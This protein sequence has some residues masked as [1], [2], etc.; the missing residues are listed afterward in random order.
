MPRRIF[1]TGLGI[2]TG[3]G[4]NLAETKDSLFHLRTG[5]GRIRYLNAGLNSDIPVSEVKCSFEE[6]FQLAG[7]P[8][9]E[10]Y[11]RNALLGMIAAKEAYLDARIADLPGLR[12]GL[13]SATTVGGMDRCELYFD[14]FL[15]N[16]SKNIYIDTYD[17]ADSTEKIADMLGIR[18]YLTT[19]STACSSSANAIQ[20]GARMILNG[21]L[22]RV[23][24][25]G[26]E[27]LTKF[28]LF[29]FD[30]LKILDKEISKPFDE[31]RN[32]I[33]LGEGAAYLVLESEESVKKSGKRILCELTG[34]GNACEAFHQ[35]ASSPDGIGAYL[36]MKKA[37]DLSGLDVADIDYINAHGTGTDNNDISEGRAIQ[38][39][40]GTA[41]PPVSSTKPYTGHTT[42]AAGATEAI[43]SIL[44][45]LEQVIWPNLNFS[46]PMKDLDFLPVKE[47]IR[48]KKINHVMSNSFGF[49]GNDTSL[50]FSRVEP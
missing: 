2:I 27:T 7:I 5:I 35:T 22:D 9:S 38:K 19:I 11:S 4:N 42:S 45:L 15:N 30:A 31:N 37:V 20:L 39:L 16:D 28:H 21:D 50:I 10:G 3:I 43:I 12:T 32:G 13:I 18:D 34:W 46:E 33:N 48:D 47:I 26:T 40:F 6:C 25:G 49:G 17:C 36:A 29:G 24:A 14:D 44:C 23:V 8:V 1:V 41:I